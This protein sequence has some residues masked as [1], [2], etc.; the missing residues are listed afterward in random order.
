MTQFS[1][2]L[3]GWGAALADLYSRK[4]DI[5]LRG[6]SGWNT[7]RAIE[8]LDTIF[9][10]DAS[11]QPALVV[12]FFGANAAAFPSPTGSG[13]QHVPIAEFQEN[14]CHI[15]AHLQGLSEKT[16]VIL[17]TAPPIHEESR[18]NWLRY[19]LS[20]KSPVSHNLGQKRV[21]RH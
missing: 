16:H 17:T 18:C 12:V 9:P 21:Q 13:G 14:L 10:K 8:A 1:F 19:V 15:A 3:G 5:L 11:V 6:Y 2:E 20:L 4:A 7:R